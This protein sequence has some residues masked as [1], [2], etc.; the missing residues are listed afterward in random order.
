MIW[1]GMYVSVSYIM[2]RKFYHPYHAG[3]EE[4]IKLPAAKISAHNSPY[5]FAARSQWAD[6]Y[7]ESP[8][9]YGP[10]LLGLIINAHILQE[11]KFKKG[12]PLQN[13][14]T[15]HHQPGHANPLNAVEPLGFAADAAVV[16]VPSRGGPWWTYTTNQTLTHEQKYTQRIHDFTWFYIVVC[17]MST[18]LSRF[19]SIPFHP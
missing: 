14:I 7:S 10:L 4:L 3:F 15:S 1:C 13:A 2:I 12:K 11:Q 17:A 5:P 16:T 9:G 19:W 6:H 18:R 8:L